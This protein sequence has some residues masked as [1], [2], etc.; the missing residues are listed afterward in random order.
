MTM[1][2]FMQLAKPRYLVPKTPVSIRVCN[3]PTESKKRSTT[4]MRDAANKKKVDIANGKAINLWFKLPQKF[5]RLDVIAQGIAE[6]SATHYI[7]RLI[8][9][10]YVEQMT[11]DRVGAVYRKI[12]R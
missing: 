12:E 2:G 7:R 4:N 9:L 10:E 6:K 1:Q 11:F 3:M 5:T 8:A